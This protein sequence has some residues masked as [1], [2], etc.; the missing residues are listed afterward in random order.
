MSE[1]KKIVE[2][3]YFEVNYYPKVNTMEI[4]TLSE[5]NLNHES[6]KEI[7]TKLKDFLKEVL[8]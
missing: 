5:F 4:R 8:E 3:H 7:L 2:D 1:K 6:D